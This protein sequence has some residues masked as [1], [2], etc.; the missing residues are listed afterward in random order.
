M[1]IKRIKTLTVMNTTFKVYWDKNYSQGATFSYQNK[2][3]SESFL[4]IGLGNK[5]NDDVLLEYI[6]HELME[7]CCIELIVRYER[8]D[9]KGEYLFC[10]DHRQHTTLMTMLAGA[11]KQF[12]A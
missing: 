8:F 5:E 3:H 12:I 6:L 7:M 4:R 9:V 11:L 2:H 1:K 10:Y